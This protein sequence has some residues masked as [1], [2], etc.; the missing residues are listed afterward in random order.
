MVVSS[1]LGREARR[2]LNFRFAGSCTMPLSHRATGRIGTVESIKAR[3]CG[4]SS[5]I[6]PGFNSYRIFQLAFAMVICHFALALWVL[7]TAL[8]FTGLR[9]RISDAFTWQRWWM[10]NLS[11]ERS[12]LPAYVNDSCQLHQ[13]QEPASI[14]FILHVHYLTVSRRTRIARSIGRLRIDVCIRS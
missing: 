7:S 1:R 13:I 9:A 5:P 4:I 2:T 8:G 6:S 11:R 3:S 14:A 10:T 12:S